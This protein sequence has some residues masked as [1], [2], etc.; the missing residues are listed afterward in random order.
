[1]RT[2]LSDVVPMDRREMGE[3]GESPPWIVRRW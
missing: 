1:M 3:A 2:V